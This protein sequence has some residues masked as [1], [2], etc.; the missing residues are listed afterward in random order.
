MNSPQPRQRQTRE[1][2]KQ[3]FESFLCSP[4]SPSSERS[5]NPG[6]KRF[7]LPLFRSQ[8]P[9]LG[10]V[11]SVPRY[12]VKQVFYQEKKRRYFPSGIAFRPGPAQDAASRRRGKSSLSPLP[13]VQ[14]PLL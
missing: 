5:E 10:S 2:S 6:E 13:A 12:R 1:T 8:P 14:A 4:S 9:S 3:F 11:K 7:E